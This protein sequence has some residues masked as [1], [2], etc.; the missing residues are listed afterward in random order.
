MKTHRKRLSPSFTPLPKWHPNLSSKKYRKQKCNFYLA[1]ILFLVL[2]Y[3]NYYFIFWYLGEG[4]KYRKSFK[5]K[6]MIFPSLANSQWL[7]QHHGTVIITISTQLIPRN[8]SLCS[9]LYNHYLPLYEYLQLGLGYNIRL[10]CLHTSL[11][12]SATE[13]DCKM[14]GGPSPPSSTGTGLWQCGIAESSHDTS[15]STWV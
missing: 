1:A 11:E 8:Q 4:R 6:L 12:P 5:S 10:R 3:F 15:S 14:A 2:L 13:E 9:L 7:Q